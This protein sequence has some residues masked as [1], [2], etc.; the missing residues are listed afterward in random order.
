MKSN[1]PLVQGTKVNI[2]PANRRK[3]AAKSFFE[4]AL[5][6]S[7]YMNPKIQNGR[8]AAKPTENGY[9]VNTY[10]QMLQNGKSE[11][12]EIQSQ[13]QQTAGVNEF[14]PPTTSQVTNSFGSITSTS[15]FGYPLPSGI[16]GF[17]SP[18]QQQQLPDLFG[19]QDGRQVVQQKQL[20]NQKT[21]L[22]E[23]SE[24]ILKN[25]KEKTVSI[26]VPSNVTL[27][28]VL[29]NIYEHMYQTYFNKRPKQNGVESNE[30]KKL[31][32]GLVQKDMTN[33]PSIVLNT[34]KKDAE[35]S[36]SA[37]ARNRPQVVKD[38][39]KKI[40]D[41]LQ[42]MYQRQVK[43]AGDMQQQHNM[44]AT[45]RTQPLATQLQQAAMSTFNTQP[46]FQQQD[47]TNNAIPSAMDRYYNGKYSDIPK[48]IL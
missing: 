15:K 38:N 32:D 45:A 33:L 3:A 31:I 30:A 43:V 41:F 18:Q 17:T 7:P 40:D 4:D 34:T 29:K 1:G 27:S 9:F 2:T 46:L 12:A 13:Y 39:T 37:H 42:K 11:N 28:T 48:F 26:K 10:S 25:G 16:N 21:T 23:I 19:I 35:L 24:N 47:S 8:S 6:T 5:S 14:I 44:A 20:V 22:G 36:S